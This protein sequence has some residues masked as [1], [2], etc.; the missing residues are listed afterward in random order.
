ML[1]NFHV[2]K[3]L[4]KIEKQYD[5]FFVNIV[6]FRF[7]VYTI[8]DVLI[9]INS[10]LLLI[11]T[12]LI[13]IVQF[14]I[15]ESIDEKMLQQ[16]SRMKQFIEFFF[17]SLYNQRQ[18]DQFELISNKKQKSIEKNCI[19]ETFDFRIHLQIKTIKFFLNDFFHFSFQREHRY[20]RHSIFSIDFARVHRQYFD[21][22]IVFSMK[23]SS[24][25]ETSIHVVI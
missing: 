12:Y 7:I 5:D 15:I 22:K 17:A 20:H 10:Q 24:M 19:F 2:T 18:L 8:Y 23:K 25:S 13:E 16:T 14:T 3:I 9:K 1:F 6:E 21:L 4:S 11:L